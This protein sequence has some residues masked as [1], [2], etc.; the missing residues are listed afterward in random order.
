MLLANEMCLLDVYAKIETDAIDKYRKKKKKM[1]SPY[2]AWRVPF[3]SQIL[4]DSVEKGP[5]ANASV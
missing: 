3:I 2:N 5:A 1:S 4:K